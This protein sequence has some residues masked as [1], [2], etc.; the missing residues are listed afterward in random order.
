MN[1]SGQQGR[2]NYP[3][4]TNSAQKLFKVGN[5]YLDASCPKK[6]CKLVVTCAATVRVNCFVVCNACHDIIAGT[7]FKQA[8]SY[9]QGLLSK[10]L[11]KWTQRKMQKI[12]NRQRNSSLK[13][14][15][16]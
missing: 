15:D 3:V 6:K 5:E 12:G 9:K 4:T 2:R 8:L 10:R 14:E 16:T 1:F 7:Y 13:I 11:E